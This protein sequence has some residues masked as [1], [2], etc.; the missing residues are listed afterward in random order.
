MA[1]P[2]SRLL[3]SEMVKWAETLAFA[4]VATNFPSHL[5]RHHSQTLSACRMAC[6]TRL[7][8]Q[9]RRPVARG[10]GYRVGTLSPAIR[11]MKRFKRAGGVRLVCAK[12]SRRSCDRAG[13]TPVWCCKTALRAFSTARWQAKHRQAKM[14]RLDRELAA[15]NGEPEQQVKHR[16]AKMPRLDQ[17]GRGS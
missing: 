12:S 6:P 17:R 3:E 16:Q 1:I 10:P 9:P 8:R 7:R 13:K 5:L 2:M 11:W 15:A 14:P 4:R